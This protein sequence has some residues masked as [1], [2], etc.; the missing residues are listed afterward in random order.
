MGKRLNNFLMAGTAVVA[1]ILPNVYGQNDGIYRDDPSL[2]TIDPTES[3]QFRRSGDV[4]REGISKDTLI[5]NDLTRMQEIIDGT[6]TDPSDPWLM[7][8][9]DINGDNQVNNQD[10]D[11]LEDHVRNHK[12]KQVA[13]WYWDALQTPEERNAYFQSVYEFDQT[14][15]SEDGGQIPIF[16]CT[17]YSQQTMIDVHGFTDPNDIADLQEVWDYDFSQ[18][19]LHGIPLMDAYIKD[20][21]ENGKISGAHEMNT[22]FVGNDALNW[23]DWNHFEPQRDLMDVQPGEAYIIG[24]NSKFEI[25]GPP[26]FGTFGIEEEKSLYLSILTRFRIN[27]LV[28]SNYWPTSEE[29][30]GQTLKRDT[31]YPT[32][33][34]SIQ[35]GFQYESSPNINIEIQDN[36]QNDKGVREG[37][38]SFDGGATK[39]LISESNNF[40]PDL[41]EGEYT[42]V[43]YGIDKTRK[44]T[45]IQKNFSIVKPADNINPEVSVSSPLEG[46]VYGSSPDFQFNV[47]DETELDSSYFSL[48]NGTTKTLFDEVFNQNPNLNFGNYNLLV[49]GVDK[50][51]N[52]TDKV[53]NFSIVEPV[54]NTSPEVNISSP[55]ENALY[56]ESPNFNFS[57]TDDKSL[58]SAYFQVN[59]GTR[60]I[61]E[62]NFSGNENLDYGEYQVSVTGVDE[63][64]NKT[65]KEVNFS[66]KDTIKPKPTLNYEID[67]NNVSASWSVEEK[68]FNPEESYLALNGNKENI[69]QEGF[70]NYQSL[71]TGENE[72]KL[73]A[74]DMFGNKDSTIKYINIT[75]VGLENE[76]LNNKMLVFPNPVNE[77]GRVRYS[78][79]KTAYLEF[80]N[81][82]GK[83]EKEIIDKDGNGETEFNSSDLKSGL[84]IIRG[85][86]ENETPLGTGKFV[87][88]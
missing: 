9:A 39:R 11:M 50:A 86:D 83:L 32:I 73:Y 77:F 12:F 46:M 74:E 72:L 18:N 36:Q 62:E 1:S 40:N 20:Y 58:D 7:Y 45:V 26:T 52:K 81:T 17:Q 78:K 8:R 59:N 60:N 79:N 4:N 54:D 34:T 63:A 16:D 13:N 35:E 84:Y 51:G 5:E 85:R 21:D 29:Q 75:D 41:P 3:L 53:V 64:G 44:E 87:K 56:Q 43:T 76:L 31:S 61:F 38:V 42:M 14:N 22:I 28:P 15:H 67:G 49:R 24:E 47:T 66:V 68:N 10:Y 2:A 82:S 33:S 19:G 65:E 80:Y 6:F 55:L 70:K 30:Y 23:N 27:D 71:P 37:W 57:V 48:D 88:R 69:S 25:R